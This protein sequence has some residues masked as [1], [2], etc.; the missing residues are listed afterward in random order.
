MKKTLTILTIA[1]FAVGASASTVS[2]VNLNSKT[3]KKK[4]SDKEHLDLN[5]M[6]M[7][8]DDEH[9]DDIHMDDKNVKKQSK[10]SSKRIKKSNK[11]SVI[12]NKKNT[13]KDNEDKYS[14]IIKILSEKPQE[15]IK[16]K[17][18]KQDK[19]RKLNKILI[20]KQAIL[21]TPIGFAKIGNRLI[22][23]GKM[24]KEV[25]FISKKDGIPG[26]DYFDDENEKK[27]SNVITYSAL[28]IGYEDVIVKISKDELFGEWK[29]SQLS[30]HQVT[31]VNKNLNEKIVKQY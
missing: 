6:D 23:Y 25:S 22:V 7:H 11:Y 30:E 17:E 21:P 5:K 19:K 10:M 2:S 4:M 1:I 29:V 15:T 16:Q 26:K 9:M 8:M 28:N 27:G 3:S 20:F 13:K 31:F 12:H 14:K 18:E 24:K